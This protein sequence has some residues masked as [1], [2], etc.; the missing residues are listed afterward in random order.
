MGAQLPPKGAQQPT[1]FWP[2]SVVAIGRPSQLLL[3][4]YSISKVGSEVQCSLK[5]TNFSPSAYMYLF[6]ACKPFTNCCLVR[7]S[8]SLY[9]CQVSLRLCAGLAGTDGDTGQQGATGSRGATGSTGLAGDMGWTGGTGLPGL[10]GASGELGQ[11]GVPGVQG[12]TGAIG[13]PGPAGFPGNN[14]LITLSLVR[15]M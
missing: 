10:V 12:A 8:V 3:S 1:I 2:M 15:C 4:T 14:M 7:I 5:F 13:T 9:V 6:F 11:S